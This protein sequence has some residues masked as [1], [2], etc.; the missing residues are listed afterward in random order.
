VLIDQSWKDHSLPWPNRGNR[1]E[2]NRGVL[3]KFLTVSQASLSRLPAGKWHSDN[4]CRMNEFMWK[5]KAV[6]E[7][8]I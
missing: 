3:S 1:E 8:K 4:V 6:T 7:E 2:Q 5:Q